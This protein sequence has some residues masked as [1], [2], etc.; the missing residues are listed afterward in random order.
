[1]TQGE[2]SLVHAVRKAQ[3]ATEVFWHKYVSL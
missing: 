3:L 2:R 1:M